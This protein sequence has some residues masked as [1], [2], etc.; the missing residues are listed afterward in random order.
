MVGVGVIQSFS[1]SYWFL[2]VWRRGLWAVVVR[3]LF[4][5]IARGGFGL[6]SMGKRGL[7]L[8]LLVLLDD[9]LGCDID[10]LRIE[11]R[12]LRPVCRCYCIPTSC[13]FPSF[14]AACLYSLLCFCNCLDASSV[15]R[16]SL[17][18]CTQVAN[19]G[20]RIVYHEVWWSYS[21][22]LSVRLL[23]TLLLSSTAGTWS[24]R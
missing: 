4:C 14:A 2:G 24:A 5:Y 12:L 17:W 15:S 8:R 16:T 6:G 19:R 10:R 13:F 18:C 9:E 21:E 20:L 23:T 11:D 22:I 7:C 1:A 3:F